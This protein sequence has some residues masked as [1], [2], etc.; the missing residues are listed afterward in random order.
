MSYKHKEREHIKAGETSIK[1]RVNWKKKK[2]KTK[3][4]VKQNN[5]NRTLTL[6]AEAQLSVEAKSISINNYL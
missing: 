5:G 2:K 1:P 6:Y 3:N 4:V